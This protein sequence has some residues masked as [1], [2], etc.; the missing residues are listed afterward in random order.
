MYSLKRYQVYL[1]FFSKNDLRSRYHQVWI[2]DK[3]IHKTTFRT[4]YGYYEFVVVPFGRTNGPAT[5]M[6]LM[7]NVL[8]NFL[9]K[10]VLVFIDDILIY[11]NIREKNE[12]HLKL[13]LQ[14]CI[15]PKKNPLLR[16]C[17]IQGSSGS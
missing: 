1:Q 2:K 9:N 5:F 4:R 12:D 14:V 16:P 15:F 7:N 13:V 3:D 10:F 8:N 17:H 6:C 11:F